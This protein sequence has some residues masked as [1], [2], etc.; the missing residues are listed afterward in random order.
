M[1][2]VTRRILDL[3]DLGHEVFGGPSPILEDEIRY[4]SAKRDLFR[5][6]A[7]STF[8]M[9]EARDAVAAYGQADRHLERLAARQHLRDGPLPDTPGVYEELTRLAEETP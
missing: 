9:E 1:T 8:D 3:I 2:T 6:A 4:Y 7:E 5:I